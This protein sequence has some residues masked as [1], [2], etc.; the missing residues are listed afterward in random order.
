MLNKLG[1]VNV[2]STGGQLYF[3]KSMLARVSH[4]A[5]FTGG[6]GVHPV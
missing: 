2:V 5:L 4:I 3:S 6:A 1:Y